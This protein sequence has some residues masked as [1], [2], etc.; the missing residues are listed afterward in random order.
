MS[1]TVDITPLFPGVTVN[2][3]EGAQHGLELITRV[4]DALRA[5][6]FVSGADAFEALAGEQDTHDDLI[7]LI[8]STVTVL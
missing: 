5:A 2:L 3:R 4:V 1:F 6:G 7:L 8:R